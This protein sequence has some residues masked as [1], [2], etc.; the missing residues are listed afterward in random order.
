M[1]PRLGSPLHDPYDGLDAESRPPGTV[2]GG[3]A[4]LTKPVKI[5]LQN[6]ERLHVIAWYCFAPLG[7]TLCARLEDP[8]GSRLAHSW[9]RLAAAVCLHI[10]V[11]LELVAG[12]TWVALRPGPRLWDLLPWRHGLRYKCQGH[13]PSDRSVVPPRLFGESGCFG[14]SRLGYPSEVPSQGR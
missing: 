9:P 14:P 8:T 10:A 11:A 1:D 6:G 5:K 2:F 13:G 12:Q 7:L 4:P 3:A